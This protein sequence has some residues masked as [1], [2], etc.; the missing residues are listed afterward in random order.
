MNA[1][2]NIEPVLF[3]VEKQIP[4]WLADYFDLANSGS[5]RYKQDFYTEIKPVVLKNFARFDGFD[6]QIIV[7]KCNSCDGTGIFKHYY[8]EY[9]HRYLLKKEPCYH[10][11]DGIY[12]TKKVYLARWI[13]NGKIYHLPYVNV[14]NDTPI[15]NE[16][17]GFIKHNPVD[18][19]K[20]LRAF[21]IL[22]W[23]YNKGGFYHHIERIA[24]LKI[25]EGYKW[26]NGLI[27]GLFMRDNL[28]VSDELPF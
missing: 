2:K 1:S 14:S 3:E 15:K 22:L 6:L 11:Y 28:K 17:K 26:I 8:Y 7:K 27:Q 18:S 4:Q 10:C 20:V 25:K 19:E 23:Q 24:E 13:L 21:I 9:G 12:M 5:Y 16:I